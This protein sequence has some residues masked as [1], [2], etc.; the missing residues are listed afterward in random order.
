MF[1]TDTSRND[2]HLVWAIYAALVVKQ[3]SP[4]ATGFVIN[5]FYLNYIT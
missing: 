1:I 3:K 2:Y 4:R 5:T